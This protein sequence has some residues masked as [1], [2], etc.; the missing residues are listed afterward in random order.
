MTA[1]MMAIIMVLT[2]AVRVPAVA[3]RG[4]VHLGDSAIFL[5]VLLLGWRYGAVAAAFGSALSDL[6]GG[7]A[8]FAPLTFVVKAIMAAVLGL[9]ME[10]AFNKERSAGASVVVSGLG[11]VL[12]GII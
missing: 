1:M 9:F 3:T 6:L 8:Y 10:K 11:M 5:A 12:A 2:Y 7:Y 4:Y